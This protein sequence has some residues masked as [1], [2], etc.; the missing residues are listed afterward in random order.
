MLQH[1]QHT[2]L[3]NS[4]LDSAEDVLQYQEYCSEEY[5]EYAGVHR[6]KLS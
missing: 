5:A 4:L 1:A 3:L 6:Q 2:I